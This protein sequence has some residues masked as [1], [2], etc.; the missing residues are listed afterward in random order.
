MNATL[1]IPD[2]ALQISDFIRSEKLPAGTRLP[3]RM[4][5]EHFR[6]SRTPVTRALRILA[7][8][9]VV[10]AATSGGYVTHADE[11]VLTPH[12]LGISSQSEEELLYLKIAEDHWDQRLPER[13]SE[14]E[15]IRRYQVTRPTVMRVLRRAANEGWAERLPGRGWSF[16]PLLS[17]DLAYEQ[18]CRYRVIVEPAAILEPSFRLDRPAVEAALVEQE[19]LFESGGRGLS[20]VEVFEI[21]SRFH[22]VVLKCSNNS[23]L[24]NGT[25]QV[26]RAR[27]LAEYKKMFDT[28]RWL[29]R[30]REHALIAK[31]LL[32]DNR[33]A[34]AD[35]MRLH[36]EKGAQE[37][38]MAP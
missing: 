4:L 6:V 23:L 27:R 13:A 38:N 11:V 26:Y 37:K 9:K 31:L 8:H 24:I 20:P 12:D 2:L 32:E 14:N 15:L 21:G 18:I 35:L 30:C 16:I 1:K 5:A 36:L 10:H 29:D 28:P 17:S 34:A 22:L 25:G 3:E 7:E 19:K 33:Q